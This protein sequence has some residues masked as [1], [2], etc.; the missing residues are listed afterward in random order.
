MLTLRMCV[1]ILVEHV[2]FGLHVAI[3]FGVTAIF[4]FGGFVNVLVAV[5][6][7]SI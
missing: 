4:L 5:T 7:N 6:L 1:A 2:S 3:K